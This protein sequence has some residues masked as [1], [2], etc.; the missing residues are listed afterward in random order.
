VLEVQHNLPTGMLDPLPAEAKSWRSPE[1]EKALRAKK[2]RA[3]AEKAA[4]DREPEEACA[5]QA[6]AEDAPI[7]EE[8]EMPEAE[9]EMPPT[10]AP[11][12]QVP[13]PGERGKSKLIQ[14]NPTFGT[15]QGENG[16]A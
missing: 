16:G 15:G 3:A 1:E 7:H 11:A 6:P 4:Q 5:G 8:P 14:A 9:T 12:D 10:P 13:N 2:R